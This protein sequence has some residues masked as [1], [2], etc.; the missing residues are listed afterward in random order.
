MSSIRHQWFTASL[1]VASLLTARSV[2]AEDI[3]I[4]ASAPPLTDIPQVV[5]VLDSSANW[6]ST[7]S[8]SGTSVGP[9]VDGGVVTY[10]QS[11]ILGSGNNKKT[12]TWSEQVSKASLGFGD[13]KPGTSAVKSF[14]VT[15]LGVTVTKNNQAQSY[16]GA[17]GRTITAMTVTGANV[18]DFTVDKTG[19]LNV[20]L[21]RNTSCTV[22]VTFAPTS[23]GTKA[24]SITF[25]TVG[26]NIVDGG[27]TINNPALSFSVDL[28]GNGYVETSKCYYKDNGVTTTDGPW[29]GQRVNGELMPK[30]QGTKMG[31][32]KCALYNLVDALPIGNNDVPLV[33]VAF[34]LY[35]ES[36]AQTG[37]LGAGSYPLTRFYAVNSLTKAALKAK[38][39]ALRMDNDKSN[40]S[41]FAKAIYEA[42]LM[43]WAQPYYVGKLGVKYD[44]GA[45]SGN[46]YISDAAGNCARNHIIL[47][48][49]GSPQENTD[50]I[51][52]DLLSSAYTAAGLTNPGPITYSTSYISNSD[53]ANWADEW[54]RFLASK[55]ISTKDGV[56]SITTHTVAVTGA[57]SDGLYP[58]FMHAIATQGGG[59]YVTAQD[60]DTLTLELLRIFNQILAQNSVFASAA[61]PVSLNTR[62][63]YENQV[64]LG[65]FRPDADVRPR[66]V[67]NLK[68]YKLAYDATSESVELVDST[69]ASA[70]SGGSGFI[71]PTVTS[72]WTE[73][74]TFW[75]NNPSGTPVSGSDKPDGAIVEKGG[76][77]QQLRSAY[78]TS[79]SGRKVYTCLSCSGT[80]TLGA[81]VA[82]QFADANTGITTGALGAGSATERTDLINWVRGTDN[83]TLDEKG[84]GS[85]TTVRP[86]IHGDVLHS[87]P[88]II[89]YPSRTVVFYG[90][91]DGLLHA[92]DGA[93]TTGTCSNTSWGGCELWS[94]VPE[95]MLGKLKRLRDDKPLVKFPTTVTEVGDPNPPVAR[96]YFVDGPIGTYVKYSVDPSTKAISVDKAYIIVGMRRGGRVL[97]AFDVTDPT[98]PKFKW[99]KS[100]TDT[101]M[102]VLGQTWSLPKVAKL[103]G[104]DTP[105]IIMGAGYDAAAEDVSPQGATT[106]GNAVLVLDLETG[107][108]V[109]KFQLDG[110]R[111]IPGDITLVD[112]D[113]DGYIDRAYAGDLG[114]KVY[115]IDFEFADNTSASYYTDPNNWKVSTLAS[116]A[117]TSQRKIMFNPDVFLGKTYSAVFA[118]TGDREKPLL[119]QVASASQRDDYFFAVVD[120][121]PGKGSTTETPPTVIFTDPD[122]AG[123]DLVTYNDFSSASSKGCYYP[124][125]ERVLGEKVINAPITVGGKTYFSTNK[126]TDAEYEGNSC[127]GDLGTAK[128]YAVPLMCGPADITELVGGGLAPSPVIGVVRIATGETDAQGNEIFKEVPFII[129]GKNAKNSPIEAS[130]VILPTSQKRTRLYWYF[131]PDR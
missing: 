92:V 61:L 75:K 71:D 44:A 23:V 116:L 113:Y 48:G 62:G 127:I 87:R 43:L 14:T 64:F 105:V 79:Q 89:S 109:R 128:S 38:I 111:A 54:A 104:R 45:F 123:N 130:R 112:V 118:G 9:G 1:A 102:A 95:E 98:T 63:T 68:Q 114:G 126:P 22:T 120:S 28:S 107:A 20:P 106:M 86:S 37:S 3:D 52:R 31:I 34:M 117:G 110:M 46:R 56:Q 78:A 72:F 5:I 55:D 121:N 84:P 47:I 39:K 65:V 91:N 131:D 26:E 15:N 100:N 85:P 88:T 115:R 124:L 96:D 125:A 119:T 8:G 67:G 36:N 81:T 129:G 11:Q 60:S 25:T 108:V 7:I 21:G 29:D 69:G 73:T 58:N 12:Y 13:Q 82:T 99:K 97:Y 4:F 30:E 80:T 41:P 53:Q 90:A 19:C 32:E 70:V 18:A 94:Y 42:F 40:N 2:P 27:N 93:P 66:W 103:K 74:S 10:S 76:A 50:N 122:A 101:N 83:V 57:P 35:L 51:A 24:A 6:D 33:K 17:H 49:N 16:N 59:M 77:A